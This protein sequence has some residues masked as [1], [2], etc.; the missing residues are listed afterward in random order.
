MHRFERACL[1]RRSHVFWIRKAVPVELATGLGSPVDGAGCVC[2]IVVRSRGT[3][4]R[5][6]HGRRHAGSRGNADS[7]PVDLALAGSLM[8]A[9]SCSKLIGD[10]A[11]GVGA[12]TIELTKLARVR[13]R[14]LRRFSRRRPR[15]GGLCLRPLG[16]YHL[17]QKIPRQG[18]NQSW[19]G[20]NEANEGIAVAIEIGRLSVREANVHKWRIS[21]G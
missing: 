21:S 16:L 2:G 12:Q 8:I 13:V 18:R 6:D 11:A 4:P 20:R 7:K 14:R 17:R 10:A 19:T 3:E 9:Q 5:F 15:R 1:S